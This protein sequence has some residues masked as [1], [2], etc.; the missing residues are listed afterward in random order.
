MAISPLIQPDSAVQPFFSFDI[1]PGHFLLSVSAFPAC[2]I[3]CVIGFT[4]LYVEDYFDLSLFYDLE[5]GGYLPV[6]SDIAMSTAFGFTLFV[7]L[8]SPTTCLLLRYFRWRM[9]DSSRADSEYQISIQDQD[10]RDRLRQ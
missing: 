4:Y 8:V 6:S 7:H 9:E 2:K 10:S 5:G 3:S 1:T